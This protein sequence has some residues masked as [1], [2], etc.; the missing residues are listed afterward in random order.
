MN[1]TLKIE[2][3]EIEEQLSKLIREQ[4]E[5]T[6][7]TLKKFLS[8]LGSDADETLNYRKKDPTKHS[9]PIIY[10]D[11]EH[12]DLHDVIPYQHVTDSAKYIHELRRQKH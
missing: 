4:K 6:I 8:A 11:N 2:N 3:A 1:I 12:E 9:K 5:V 10:L 7:E